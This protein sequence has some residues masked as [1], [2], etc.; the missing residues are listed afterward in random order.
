[1]YEQKLFYEAVGSSRENILKKFDDEISFLPLLNKG[2]QLVDV[3]SKYDFPIS[4]ENTIFSRARSP[5]RISFGGGGQTL[6][7][8]FCQ[9]QVL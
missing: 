5:V 4:K 9:V 8:I 7:N 1:M 6:Q 2:K 3:I